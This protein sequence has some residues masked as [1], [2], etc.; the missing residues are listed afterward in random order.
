M[1]SPDE[2][3]ERPT[4][5]QAL[6]SLTGDREAEAKALADRADEATDDDALEAVRSAHGDLGVDATPADHDI[7][8][9]A[10]AEAVHGTRAG[11]PPADGPAADEP[12]DDPK[13]AP[14]R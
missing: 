1:A 13:V 10:D 12:D 8:T 3:T 11:Q 4:L 14:V 5:R 6:H 9:P 7:A 2:Q